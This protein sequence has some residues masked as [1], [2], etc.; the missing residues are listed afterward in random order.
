M[1]TK[2]R[3]FISAVSRE[4]E[5]SRQV[6]ANTLLFLGYEPVWQDIIGV[7]QGEIRAVLR[8]QIDSCSG[9]VQLVG[10]RYGSNRGNRIRPLAG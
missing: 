6:V 7:E 3:I 10:R 5:T 1:A 2:P 4:L 8:R 9:L